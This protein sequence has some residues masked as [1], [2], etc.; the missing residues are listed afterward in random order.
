V[1]ES[2]P[3]V[4]V[5]ANLRRSKGHALFLE[6]WPAVLRAF[7]KARALLVGDGPLRDA[8]RAKIVALGV[9]DSVQLLGS[10]PDVP[11]LL[12]LSEVVAQPSLREGFPNAILEALAAGRPVVATDVGGTREAIDHE[13]TGLLVPSGDASALAAGLVRLLSNPDE[14][15]GLGHAGRRHVAEHFQIAAM[16][17][18]HEAA[19]DR[20]LSAASVLGRARRAA[21]GSPGA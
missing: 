16:V 13:R 1:A 3:I 8:V 9:G 14:A 11:A 18:A 20:V 17:R 10:R 21:P 12:A 2:S 6:A 19:Y 5:V 7:P 4:T 15:R